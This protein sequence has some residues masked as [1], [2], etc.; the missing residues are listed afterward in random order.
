M[1]KRNFQRE[2]DNVILAL[3][4]ARPSLMLHSCCGPCSSYVIEYLSRHFELTVFF[5][6]PNIHPEQEYLRRLEAQ[7]ALVEQLGA[8]PL[9]EGEYAPKRFYNAVKGLETERE[10]GLRCDKCIAERMRATALRAR[11]DGF[12]YFCTTLSVSPHK[13]AQA[14]NMLGFELESELGVKWLPSD[15]KKKGGYLRSIELSKQ[16]GIYRQ[17]YCG[18]E[19]SKTKSDG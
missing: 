18:C 11:E 15:F 13:N 6:N 9:V 19:Y 7:R 10:G 3:G 1:E 8:T 16:Y 14:I 5:Y 2:T 12:E 17:D 4:S